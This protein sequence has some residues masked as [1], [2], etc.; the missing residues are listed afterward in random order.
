[1]HNINLVT[2]THYIF[3]IKKSL[4]IAKQKGLNIPIVYNTSSYEKKESLEK[5]NGL[6][7]IYLPDLKYFDDINA[8]KYSKAPMYFLYATHAIDEMFRQVGK[9]KFN[10]YGIMEKGVIVRHMML[11]GNLE[12]SKKIIKYLY[13]TYK[14]N[15][16]ISIMNQ[17]TPTIKVKN[18]NELNKTVS[19][20]EYN[21][22]ID[23]AINLGMKN[24]F[25]QEDGSNNESF[26]PK[27]DLTGIEK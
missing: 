9:P 12:D 14:D 13:D 23:Y 21:E 22:L 24:A 17:Y 7:D 3:S 6:I 11:P 5:L 4:E 25:I 20:N 15:I 16:F 1:M 19:K 10:K 26:I 27:F 2:P 18:I 8:V